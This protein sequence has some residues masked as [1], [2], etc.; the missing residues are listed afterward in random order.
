[1]SEI[2]VEAYPSFTKEYVCVDTGD[3]GYGSAARARLYNWDEINQFITQLTQAGVEAFGP[4]PN[5]TEVSNA[6]Q[7]E[8]P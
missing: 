4:Q 1:M 2:E 8:T 3:G 6:S 5:S 7:Q